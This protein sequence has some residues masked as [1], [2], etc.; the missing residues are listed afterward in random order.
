M[1]LG[2]C[3]RREAERLVAAGRVKV[4]G[5]T[6]QSENGFKL[7]SEGDQVA[8]DGRVLQDRPERWVRHIVQ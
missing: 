3:S 6:V 7:V 8:V 2:V 4:N 5:E 1:S